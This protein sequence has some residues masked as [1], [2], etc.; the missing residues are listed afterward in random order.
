MRV[1]RFPIEVR[2]ELGKETSHAMAGLEAE[3]VL[4]F[5]SSLLLIVGAFLRAGSSSARMAWR[6]DS[7]RPSPRRNDAAD[8]SEPWDADED[9]DV[10][11]SDPINTK[12][13]DDEESGASKS[14]R[15]DTA[16]DRYREKHETANNAAIHAP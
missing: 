7:A 1:D 12:E 3:V 8:A 9:V 11:D 13:D 2:T 15:D 14:D 10:D 16:A 5:R 4:K 6:G